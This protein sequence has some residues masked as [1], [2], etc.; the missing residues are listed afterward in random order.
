MSN[1]TAD[2]RGYLE[3]IKVHT[4]YG[5]DPQQSQ[6][7]EGWIYTDHAA[8]GGR[9]PFVAAGKAA[10][11]VLSQGRDFQI[12]PVVT[13]VDYP[14]SG[15]GVTAR[16]KLVSYPG[17]TILD[18]RNIHFFKTSNPLGQNCFGAN[19]ITLSGALSIPK[20]KL[21]S[22][23]VAAQEIQVLE[24]VLATD[25]AANGGHHPVLLIGS[26]AIH[27]YSWFSI[28]AGSQLDPLMATV[29]G[30]LMTTGNKSYVQVTYLSLENQRSMF[31]SFD[32]PGRNLNASTDSQPE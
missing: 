8:L 29:G 2:I 23:R 20:C 27:I 21:S 3:I 18:V 32:L 30:R 11:I 28:K 24:G 15:V 22:I 4:E 14:N 10:E 5:R 26:E 6:C 16:G 13:S 31:F 9:H 19:T 17:R 7:I 25:H 1:N 12:T